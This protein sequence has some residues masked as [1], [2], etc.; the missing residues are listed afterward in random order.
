M[1]K[2]YGYELSKT[3]DLDFYLVIKRERGGMQRPTV[4]AVAGYPSLHR[5]ERAINLK[6]SL[7]LA[8]FETPSLSASITVE[9]PEQAVHIDASAVSEAVR[10]VTGLDVD[11]RVV[12]P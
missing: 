5:D 8:L 12:G 6:M 3:L 10:Q 7:P 11:I 4:R 1:P 2:H 9:H